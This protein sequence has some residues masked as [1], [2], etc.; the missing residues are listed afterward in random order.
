MHSNCFNSQISHRT[1]FVVALAQVE[2]CKSMWQG[3]F[4]TICK[5]DFDELVGD[6][7][8]QWCSAY[9]MANVMLILNYSVKEIG[10]I[11]PFS[12]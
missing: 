11:S 10:F 5:A 7:I 6:P 9:V 8:L 1:V 3:S 2:F 4:L 12:Y